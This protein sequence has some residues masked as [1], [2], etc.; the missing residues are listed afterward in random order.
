MIPTPNY[1]DNRY[2]EQ[3]HRR[4]MRRELRAE[5]RRL[6]RHGSL[7]SGRRMRPQEWTRHRFDGQSYDFEAAYGHPLT[8]GHKK[9]VAL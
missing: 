3:I 7:L 8:D 2:S 5:Q 6:R 1:R 9:A 4:R